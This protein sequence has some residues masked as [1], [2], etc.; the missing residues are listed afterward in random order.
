[1]I[2]GL[3]RPKKRLLRIQLDDQLF[4]DVEV[5]VLTLGYI[6]NFALEGFGVELDPLGHNNLRAA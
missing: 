4:V 6:D 5:D 1:M 2:A 3:F